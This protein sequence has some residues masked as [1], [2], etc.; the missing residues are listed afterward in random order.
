MSATEK[1]A[2]I[3]EAVLAC[4]KA[5]GLTVVRISDTTYGSDA[6]DAAFARD[7]AANAAMSLDGDEKAA[8]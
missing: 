4:L 8:A 7:V 3:A 2:V 6:G 5:Q 1:A